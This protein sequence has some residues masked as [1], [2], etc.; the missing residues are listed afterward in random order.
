MRHL[1][2]HEPA[3]LVLLAGGGCLAAATSRGP[4]LLISKSRNFTCPEHYWDVLR[5]LN[6]SDHWHLC[7]GRV[8]S[9]D[10]LGRAAAR[11]SW[12]QINMIAQRMFCFKVS[13]P[14]RA[15]L[16][17]PRPAPPRGAASS[18][19]H[20]RSRVPSWP[21]PSPPHHYRRHHHSHHR[22]HHY[23]SYF[24]RCHLRH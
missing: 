23:H 14:G 3:L 21:L 7:E 9:G 2:Y 18:P 11:S 1:D 20:H 19:Y 13:T 22:Y 4:R 6:P 24:C 15:S 16:V 17:P 10:R 8:L 12:R 5:H